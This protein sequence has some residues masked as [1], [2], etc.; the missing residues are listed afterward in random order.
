M[1]VVEVKS[2]MGQIKEFTLANLKAR[3]R[4]TMAGFLWVVL[5]PILMYSVQS[6]V[7]KKFLNLSLPDYYLF[8]LGGLLP[9]I[10]IVNTLEMC[11]PIIVSSSELLKSYKLSPMVLVLSQIFDNLVNFIFAFF[12]ILIPVWAISDVNKFGLFFL[13]PS[14]VVL[15]LFLVNASLLFSLAN[16]F[17]RDLKF[18]LSFVTHILFFLT[19]IFY[20]LEF[21]PEKFRFFVEFNPFYL[22]IKPFRISLY[23]FSLDSYLSAL[24]QGL[25]VLV[26]MTALTFYYWKKKKNEIYFYL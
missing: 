3:Y 6:F 10:F 20:P 1:T 14:V 17:Y 21:V 15:I 23:H 26:I 13:L 19:P 9:W 11:T 22:V 4:K 8:L 12:I 24:L 18:L 5:N 7:F 25:L 2:M 16:V